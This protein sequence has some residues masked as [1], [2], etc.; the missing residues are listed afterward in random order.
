MAQQSWIWH[1]VSTLWLPTCTLWLPLPDTMADDPARLSAMAGF[2]KAA[3]VGAIPKAPPPGWTMEPGQYPGQAV[4]VQTDGIQPTGQDGEAG[5]AVQA[6]VTQPTGHDGEA[7]QAAQADGTQPIGQVDEAGQAG[8]AAQAD[9][10]DEAGESEELAVLK[11]IQASLNDIAKN[12][13]EIWAGQ[14]DQLNALRAVLRELQHSYHLEEAAAAAAAAAAAWQEQ[15]QPGN[16][17]A[18][19]VQQQSGGWQVAD[20]LPDQFKDWQDFQERG[21]SPGQPAL[22][23]PYLRLAYKQ[24]SDRALAEEHAC[25]SAGCLVKLHFLEQRSESGFSLHS[26]IERKFWRARSEFLA[27]S[28]NADL[29]AMAAAK[30][31]WRTYRDDAIELRWRQSLAWGCFSGIYYRLWKV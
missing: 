4:V 14:T 22:A 3:S 6:D 13:Y 5:Q 31:D 20:W 12:M 11:G 30:A 8:Q 19:V 15:H 10:V 9:R 2:S 29:P 28:C 17:N 26:E 27:A 25:N 18:L 1:P 16:S 23:V 21:T 24:L 7:G